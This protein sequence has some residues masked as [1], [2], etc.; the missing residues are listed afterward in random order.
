MNYYKQ[1]CENV[2][3]FIENG[4]GL[5]AGDGRGDSPG[6]SAK[7]CTLLDQTSNI[8]ICVSATQV[9][10]AGNLNVMEQ[11][12]FIKA[13]GEVEKERVTINQINQIGT[14]KFENTCEKNRSGITHQFDA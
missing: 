12:G 3:N 5:F 1:Q 8:V 4:N 10:E 6:H 14:S 7:Y 13:P 2:T 9:T 11:M